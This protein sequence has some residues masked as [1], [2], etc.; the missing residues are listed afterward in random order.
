MADYLAAFGLSSTTFKVE[1][2]GA[3]VPLSTQRTLAA[4]AL[5][6][7]VELVFVSPN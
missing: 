7:R 6:R 4:R 1:S 3:T 5:N 2:R